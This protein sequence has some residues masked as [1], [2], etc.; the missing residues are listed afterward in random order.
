MITIPPMDMMRNRHELVRTLP[1][2]CL[3]L[4][5]VLV[6][7]ER[8]PGQ[9]SIMMGTCGQCGRVGQGLRAD[10]TFGLRCGADEACIR[11]VRAAALALERELEAERDP[12][13]QA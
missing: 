9:D 8:N 11:R 6:A 12:E 7:R 1:R 5:R 4:G 2:H 13:P 10:P 3:L